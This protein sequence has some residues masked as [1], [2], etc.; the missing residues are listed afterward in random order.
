MPKMH[1]FVVIFSALVLQ[2]RQQNLRSGEACFPCSPYI[3]DHI[4][5]NI[6]YRTAH[7]HRARQ[8]SP[9]HQNPEPFGKLA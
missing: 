6:V 8:S 2:Y 3:R 7:Q 1:S 5:I 9:Q 4:T